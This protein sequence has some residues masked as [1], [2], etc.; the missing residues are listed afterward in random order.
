MKTHASIVFFSFFSLCFSAFASAGEFKVRS[1]DVSLWGYSVGTGKVALVLVSGGPGASS[2]YLESLQMLGSPN[3]QVVRFDLRGTG[4]SSAPANEKD[5]S[6]ANYVED[7]E[8]I[9]KAV[10]AEQLHVFGHSYGGLTA[11]NYAAKYPERV[12]SLILYGSS[13]TTKKMADATE[14]YELKRKALIELGA[15]EENPQE[16]T[17]EYYRSFFAP[18][19]FDPWFKLP[20]ELLSTTISDSASKTLEQFGDYDFKSEVAKITAPTL[21][22]TG[23]A[24]PYE[25]GG[26]VTILSLKKD[27]A[28]A[29]PEVKLIPQCGHQW[30]ECRAEAF[31]VLSGFLERH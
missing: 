31:H 7:L 20:A 27:L 10:G 3:V 1:G 6:P 4:R 15:I 24:D 2:D 22:V 18:L 16:G 13:P 5:Y 23:E 21:L 12:K 17:Y 29:H 28:N 26:R 30:Q 19:F 9:R 14:G 8:A 25:L 11:M